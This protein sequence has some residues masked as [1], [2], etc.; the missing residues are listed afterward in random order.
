MVHIDR[1]VVGSER[2]RWHPGNPFQ[3]KRHGDNPIPPPDRS[4]SEV[5]ASQSWKWLTERFGRQPRVRR[6]FAEK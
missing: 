4:G 6:V 5:F 1:T 3:M 2:R